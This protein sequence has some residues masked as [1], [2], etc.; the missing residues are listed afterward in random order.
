MTRTE[1]EVILT[2]L[3][4]TTRYLREISEQMQEVTRYMVTV[5]DNLQI[6]WARTDA[7]MTDAWTQ[8][9]NEKESNTHE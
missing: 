4:D 2:N 7:A 5:A 9:H 8:L 1:I 6:V 3:A